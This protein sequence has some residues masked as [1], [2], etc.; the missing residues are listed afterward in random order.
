M[1]TRE[2]CCNGSEV[3]DSRTARG[4]TN[5]FAE[6]TPT[7]ATSAP[8]IATAARQPNQMMRTGIRAADIDAPAVT[9]ICFMAIVRVRKPLET[10]ATTPAFVAGGPGG[11]EK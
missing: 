4:L 7:K 8:T 9:P 2:R 11:V 3:S 6:T 5:Q 1:T 10:H